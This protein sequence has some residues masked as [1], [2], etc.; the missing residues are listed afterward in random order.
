MQNVDQYSDQVCDT[1]NAAEDDDSVYAMAKKVKPG[2]TFCFGHV[3]S[4]RGKLRTIDQFFC[5]LQLF[6]FY[7]LF[8]YK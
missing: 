4:G 6:R 5:I 1:E 7:L 8:I 2:L 3:A